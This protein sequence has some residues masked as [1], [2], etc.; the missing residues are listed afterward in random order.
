MC[1]V[2]HAPHSKSS[3]LQL[4]YIGPFFTHF[5]LP[6]LLSPLGTYIPYVGNRR[7]NEVLPLEC[8]KVM[9]AVEKNKASQEELG[10]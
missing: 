10:V 5:T 2:F 3:F 1:P 9:N 6:L 4:P 7:R 8:E